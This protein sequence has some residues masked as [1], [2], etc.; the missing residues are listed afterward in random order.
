[1]FY[2]DLAAIQPEANLDL[3]TTSYVVMDLVSGHELN[4]RQLLKEPKYSKE[5][6]I[7]SSNE[8]DRLSQGKTGRVKSIDTIFFVHPT[9]V[10]ADSKKMPPTAA[11]NAVFAQTNK[12]TTKRNSPS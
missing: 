1:M 3:L 9:D 7:S 12:N 11:Y 2:A 8:F 6:N 10:P 5:W 4:Y